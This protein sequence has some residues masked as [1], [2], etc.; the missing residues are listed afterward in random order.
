MSRIKNIINFDSA[1]WDSIR[2]TID[3]INEHGE[4]VVG[5]NSYGEMII[6]DVTPEGSLHTQ[7]TQSNG[8]IRHNY[9]DPEERIVEEMYEK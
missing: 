2:D 8:W 6:L 7:V 5:T 4:M 1:N 9:Y 3:K